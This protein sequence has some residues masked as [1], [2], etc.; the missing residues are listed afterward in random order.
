M[1]FCA[2][3]L[4]KKGCYVIIFIGFDPKWGTGTCMFQGLACE[5]VPPLKNT[6]MVGV[7]RYE[8]SYEDPFWDTVFI[9]I[10][11]LW[12]LQF[13]SPKNDVQNMGKYTNNFYVFK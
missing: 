5:Y 1:H 2:C 10:N 4:K 3:L 9:L 8:N 12:V 11:A 7:P 6:F 13:R